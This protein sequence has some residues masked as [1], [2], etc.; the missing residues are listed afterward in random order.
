M[1]T[2]AVLALLL[3]ASAAAAQTASYQRHGAE[4]C[5]CPSTDDPVCGTDQQT[6]LN[7]CIMGCV[8]AIKAKVRPIHPL[9]SQSLHSRSTLRT[10]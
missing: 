8:S 1:R 5:N 6:Y 3:L 7:E 4:F 9:A 10:S 2:A